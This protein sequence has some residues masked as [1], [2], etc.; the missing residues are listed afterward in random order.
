MVKISK[1]MLDFLV[2]MLAISAIVLTLSAVNN[3]RLNEQ[4][5]QLYK[6]VQINDLKMSSS[7]NKL[8]NTQTELS[9]FK[10]SSRN[11]EIELDNLSLK[12]IQLTNENQQLK[13]D[14]AVKDEEFNDI[15]DYANTEVIR[16]NHEIT[17]GSIECRNGATMLYALYEPNGL[18]SD[19][20]LPLILYLHGKGAEGNNLKMLY[21]G[22]T[23]FTGF[24]YEGQITP[25]AYIL[26][27]QSPWG[28]WDHYIEDLMDLILKVVAEKNIDINR[29]SITGHSMGG[30]GTL[31][32]LFNYPDFFSAAA[33]LSTIADVDKCVEYLL[34]VPI[35]F[36]IG[37]WDNPGSFIDAA[38]AMT[39]AGAKDAKSIVYE[40]DGHIIPYHYKDN[41][42]ELVNWLIS[43]SKE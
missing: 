2:I 20:E 39:L 1:K 38:N 36:C 37:K 3:H 23:A 8:N 42:C 29:I 17:E 6:E 16:E 14:M 5:N 19:K 35:R 21:N 25:D 26:M 31:S 34:D 11:L 4:L 24:V 40:Q 18:D 27:P 43:Q 33:P 15:F 10:S 30:S 7:T 32:M 22:T 12:N 9:E 13:A 28:N 41:D